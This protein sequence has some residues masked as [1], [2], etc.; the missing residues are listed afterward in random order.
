MTPS[1]PVGDNQPPGDADDYIEQ[2]SHD[3]GS[4]EAAKQKRLPNL[5][6]AVGEP[7]PG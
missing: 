1:E 6:Q 7:F 3:G 5:D 4:N 2:G